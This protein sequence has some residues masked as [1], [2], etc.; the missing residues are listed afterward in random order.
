[1]STT[2]AVLLSE[3]SPAPIAAATFSTNKFGRFADTP[4]LQP[5]VVDL[6]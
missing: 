5:R 2:C 3:G 1:M 6:S 4:N